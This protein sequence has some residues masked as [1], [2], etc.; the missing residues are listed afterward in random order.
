MV[1]K[2]QIHGGLGKIER[3]LL[4]L[5]KLDNELRLEIDKFMISRKITQL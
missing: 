1:N 3:Y 4:N 2:G 5:I